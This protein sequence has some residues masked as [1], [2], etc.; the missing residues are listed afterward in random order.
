M[1]VLAVC[2]TDLS[3][4]YLLTERVYLVFYRSIRNTNIC[5]S[6]KYKKNIKTVNML[7]LKNS[8]T[9]ASR[10]FEKHGLILIFLVNS[11]S[12]F[13]RMICMFNFPCTFTFTYF[14]CF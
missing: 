8:P 13:L 3:A 7:C 5:L 1:I 4:S 12:T 9:L 11:I 14:I 2:Y 10:S 6:I